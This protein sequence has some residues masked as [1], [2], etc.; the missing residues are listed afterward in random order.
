MF[1]H[2]VGVPDGDLIA[3]DRDNAP[4]LP[5]SVVVDPAFT[6]GDD[7]QPRTP[8]HR[9]VI[10]EVHVKG[11]TARQPDVPRDKRGTYSGLASPAAVEHLQRLG[12][13][14]VEL[15]PVHHSVTEKDLRDRGLTNYWGYNSIG[16]FAPDARYSSVGA[17]GAQVAEFKTMVKTLHQA[18]IEVILDV[19]YNH[20]AEGNHLGP[21][22][23]FRGIDN[24][25][26]YR[27][28][29]PG[30]APLHRLHGLRQHAQHDAPAHDPAHHGQPALLGARHARR[31][32]PLRPRR[33]AGAGAPRRRPPVGVLRR[34]PPGPGHLAGQADRGAL[35]PR[36]RRLSGRQLPGGLGGV[37]REV[38]RHRP[39]LLAG[40]RGAA[41]GAGLSP[42]GLERPLRGGRA[43]AVRE[44]ELRHRPR[45]LHARRSRRLRRQ[46][47]RGQR[48]GQPRRH[49]PQPLL[50]LRGR[51]ADG[52][53]E[54]PGASRAADA[55]LPRHA[56]PVPGHSRCSAAATRSGAARA[57]TTTRT[58]RTTT[59]PGSSGHCR[60]R[61]RGSSSSPSA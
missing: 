39:P 38:P 36:R 14:A 7:R 46:A 12:V 55:Q 52:R 28:D 21:T 56:L 54:D 22:L 44:R 1:G 24:A 61:P 60:G 9:T 18:G 29:E 45:R 25:A 43:A 17:R 35:G 10:Y 47:Q 23:S 57:A 16:F 58:A 5:K 2:R 33:H 19:V 3:D 34:H 31:R 42:D 59:S 50:E 13:T 4:Y 51:R 32:L 8:W 41:L 6:W 15:L 48:R 30:P 26:Y 20:T 53:R 27:L 37:E 49:R 40:R 11:F